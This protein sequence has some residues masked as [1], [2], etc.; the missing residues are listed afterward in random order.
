MP[1]LPDPRALEKSMHEIA[2]SLGAVGTEDTPLN[3]AQ[4]LMYDAFAQRD[5]AEGVRLAREALAISPDC[6]DAYVL[7]AEHT[8]RRK[9]ALELYR[10]GVA[11]GERALGPEAFERTAGHFWGVLETRP[12]MRARLG[13][14]E[15]LWAAGERDEAVRH[16]QDMLHLNPGDNQG[17]R[18]VL[19]GWLLFLD[20]DNDLA[21]L[22]GQYPEDVMAAW[23][24]TRAL[25]AFRQQGDALEARQLLKQAKK[26][27]AH[28]PE[29][30][31]G[32]KYPPAGPPGYY[33]RGDES[34]ALNYLI[35]SMLAWKSTPGAIAWVRDN[36]KASKQRKAAAPQGKGPLG[37][38]KKW[39]GEHLPQGD[40]VWQ[41]DVRRMPIWVGE[42]A[43]RFRPWVVMVTSRS[44]DLVLAHEILEGAP[45]EALLW[46][47]LVRALQHPIAGEAHRPAEIQVRSGAV[48]ESLA[49]HL[50]E[51]GIRLST[52]DALDQLDGAFDSMCEHVCGPRRPGLLDAPGVS[53]ELAA[54]FYDAAAFYFQ[55]APWKKVG[56][57]SALK[58]EC[59]RF[60]SGPWYAVVMGGSGLTT[61]LALYENPDLLRRM[62]ANELED[63]ENA[64][65]TVGFSVQYGEPWDIVLADLDAAQQ[66][67]WKVARPDAYPSVYRKERGRSMRPPLAWELGLLEACLRAVPAF[68]G[69]RR[70]DDPT[71]ETMTV[72]AGSGALTLV[73][74][75][76]EDLGG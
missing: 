39:L 10:Q 21:G 35:G 6:A 15:G 9:E 51:I 55:Q 49:R 65:E 11:A 3:R 13:L 24:Y 26:A 53:P 46:D 48:W 45:S 57:E 32:R 37:F 47:A 31:L 54:S 2:R 41:A 63:E 68:V 12:Y 71:P 4:E 38:V 14:A 23:A 58:I 27:N 44:E 5:P 8:S 30:L 1:D 19:A 75:W 25:L 56:Y 42:G 40:D 64:E 43:D 61:G 52:A 16:L 76:V 60:T 67:G 22:L 62:W 72:P 33:S 66:Y 74:S 34:E 73:L 20:R 69:R 18:Y 29:Y 36:D 50:A 28:V 7:L 59:D 70:Q 17:L